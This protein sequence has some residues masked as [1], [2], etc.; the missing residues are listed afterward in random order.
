MKR[1]R[2]RFPSPSGFEMSPLT[3]FSRSLNNLRPWSK[4]PNYFKYVRISTVAPVEMVIRAHSGGS[5][6]VMGLM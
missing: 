2:S 4:D 6:E 1:S 3:T 5:L